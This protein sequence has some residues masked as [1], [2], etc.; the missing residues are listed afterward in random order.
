MPGSD[1]PHPNEKVNQLVVLIHT[2]PMRN[3]KELY[4]FVAYMDVYPYTKHQSNISN[5]C[6]VIRFSINFQQFDWEGAKLDIPGHV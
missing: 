2:F 5:F 6:R 3:W 4:Q 1:V